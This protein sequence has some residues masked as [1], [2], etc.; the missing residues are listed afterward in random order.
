MEF[1]KCSR[2]LDGLHRENFVDDE[3]DNASYSSNQAPQKNEP[4]R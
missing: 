2:R 3:I 4:V 1:E